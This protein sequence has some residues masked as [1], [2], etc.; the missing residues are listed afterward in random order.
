M[1]SGMHSI[2]YV[3]RQVS[4]SLLKLGVVS[5]ALALGA[6]AMNETQERVGGG[7]ALGAAAGAILGS[8]RESAAIGAAVGA[9]GGYIYDQ[10][11]KNTE[12]EDENAR[13]RAENERLMQERSED[14]EY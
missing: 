2:I 14:D 9:A 10:H 5:L 12:S 7:A 1:P 11:S 6:C 13:L 3:T 4:R 8:S